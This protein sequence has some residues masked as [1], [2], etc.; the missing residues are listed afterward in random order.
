MISGFDG[1]GYQT[2]LAVSEDLLHWE[3][4]VALEEGLVKTIAYFRT[5]VT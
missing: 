5:K 1:R 2:A 3:P 4:K